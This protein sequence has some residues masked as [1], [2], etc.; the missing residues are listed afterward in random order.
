M[1][2]LAAACGGA[3][4]DGGSTECG[5]GKP[6]GAGFVCNL[7][8]ACVPVAVDAA[9]VFDARP[10]DAAPPPCDGGVVECGNLLVN[11]G[12]EAPLI[13]ANSDHYSTDPQYLPGWTLSAGPNQFF[14]ENGQP[15]GRARYSEGV[16]G[17][18]LNGDGAPNVYIEQTFPTTAGATYQLSF[19]MTDE[20]VAGPSACAVKVD[21]AG[22]TMTFTRANDTGFAT[23]ELTFQATATTTTLRLTDVTPGTSALSNPL[24]DAVLVRP[25]S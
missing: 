6:C 2:V 12:F 5:A 10:P 19:A 13:G 23:K 21:V 24:I 9:I 3:P 15:F 14:Q 17:I 22:V 7:V 18:C 4:D 20:Q 11:G 1:L 8:G 16:Q 25:S